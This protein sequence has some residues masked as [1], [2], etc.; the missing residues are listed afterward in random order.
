MP[1]LNEDLHGMAPDKSEVA[2]ILLDVINDMAFE[3]AH[4]LL[5]HA[6]EAARRIAA[7][8]QRTRAAGI[9]AIYVND[10]FG[11]W[12]SDFRSLIQHCLQDACPGREIA[13][14]LFPE[15]DDYFILKPK[16]SGFFST[17][18]D[19]LLSYLGVKTLIITGFAGDICVLFT[20]NDAYMRDFHLVTPCDCV[21]SN[22]TE[23]NARAVRQMHRVLKANVSPSTELDLQALLGRTLPNRPVEEPAVALSAKLTARD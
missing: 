21:A 16:H 2:L 4:L 14:L 5:P 10:N 3:E 19:V 22:C 11:R 1:A 12:R 13:Q 17:T 9:P 20:A 7:L 6:R 8:K 15:E 23:S 18:L